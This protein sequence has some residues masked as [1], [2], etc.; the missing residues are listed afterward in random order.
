MLCFEAGKSQLTM[1][2]ATKTCQPLQWKWWTSDKRINKS[3]KLGRDKTQLKT[4]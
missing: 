4:K 2:D 3:V 1:K